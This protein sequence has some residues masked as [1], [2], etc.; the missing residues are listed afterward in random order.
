MGW[1]L[2]EQ[3]LEGFETGQTAVPPPA[4]NDEQSGAVN[5]V[6]SSRD[7]FKPFLLHG[8]TGSGKTE[9]YM[10][11][12]QQMLADSEHHNSLPISIITTSTQ[13]ALMTI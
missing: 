11:I 7:T 4:L 12:L 2:R 13:T 5:A 9:V 6:V 1:V 8:I 3:V 10:Q